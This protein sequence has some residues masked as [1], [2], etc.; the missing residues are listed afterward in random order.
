VNRSIEFLEARD[1]SKPF[2]M[3]VWFND[4]HGILDPTPEQ[5]EE[6]NYLA[7]HKDDPN[8]NCGAMRVYYSVIADIDRQVG[9]LLDK[10]DELGLADNTVVI[11]TSDNG[12][13]PVWDPGT[14][15]SGS[16]RTGPFRGIK[17]S[18]YE[19]GVRMP[20]IMRW[21]GKTPQDRVDNESVV[22]ATDL[23]PTFCRMAG[24]E[25]PAGLDG[26][27]VTPVFEGASVEREQPVFWEYRFGSWGRHIQ[28]S[29]RY[30]MRKGNWKLMMNADGTAFELFDLSSDKSET[31]NCAKYETERVNAMS[32]ELM[33]WA[34]TLP[35]WGKG[36]QEGLRAY[37][38][39]KPGENTAAADVRAVAE[40]CTM[41]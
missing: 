31:A 6:F 22:S 35:S 8:R 38:W 33:E 32:K 21:P 17:A 4:P 41:G 11:F 30:A 3:N 20:F 12:P 18:L 28:L 15:N 24:V 19:G 36:D 9:R 14:A 34:R 13:A 40:S 25:P 7:A 10:L 1:T 2:Y 16:G 26:H 29:L 37:P 39:P 27:D 5:M 23:L